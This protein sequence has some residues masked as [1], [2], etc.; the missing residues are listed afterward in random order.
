MDI[1]MKKHTFFRALFLSLA[2]AAMQNAHAGSAV[3][4]NGQRLYAAWGH[5]VEQAKTL[6][7]QTGQQRYGGHFKVVAASAVEG[8]GAIAV[9]TNGRGP[10]AVIGIS[11]GQASEQVAKD[12]SVQQCLK[13]G[14]VA[15]KVARVFKG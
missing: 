9:A 14:G 15:P 4:W 13:A 10:G 5:P 7:L 6:A 12:H 11:L 3:V 8:Y 2:V 1:L